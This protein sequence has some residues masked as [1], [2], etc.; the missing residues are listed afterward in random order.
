MKTCCFI[1]HRNAK[2]TPSLLEDLSNA[3]IDLIQNKEVT[4][5]LFG[6]KSMFDDLC[7]K[8]VTDIKKEY[9]QIK[10]VYYRSMYAEISEGYKDYLL[11]LYD[12]TLIPKGVERAG[13]ASYLERNQNMI[14]SSDYCIFYY[15]KDYLPPLRKQTKRAIS[16]YQPKSGT[17][18]AYEH[19]EKK[20]KQIINLYK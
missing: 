17:R 15:D 9:P 14:D 4:T 5:F 10:L 11:E 6:S 13:K 8:V 1:G 18:L 7:L 12:D 19:A 16:T 2:E 20:K 3:V